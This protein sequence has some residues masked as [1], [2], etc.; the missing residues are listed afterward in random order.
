[1]KDTFILFNQTLNEL[2]ELTER[3]I[4]SLTIEFNINNLD[5][6]FL[7]ILAQPFEVFIYDCSQLIHYIFEY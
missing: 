6:I 5:H 1:M 4:D 7:I 2:Y 3:L